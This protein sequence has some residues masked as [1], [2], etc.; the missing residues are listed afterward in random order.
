MDHW[1]RNLLLNASL[2]THEDRILI[3]LLLS[4]DQNNLFEHW[5]PPGVNDELKTSLM[6]QLHRLHASYLPAEGGL[7]A[8]IRNARRLLHNS[9]DC[10]NDLLQDWTPSIP[11]GVSIAPFTEEFS[12]YDQIGRHE[13]VKL[14]FVL[15]AG[16]MS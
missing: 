16:G 8:Y 10:K 13:V 6:C 15:V 5:D 2:L 9:K 11:E 14:G 1:P 12:R 3:D 7:L 4:V